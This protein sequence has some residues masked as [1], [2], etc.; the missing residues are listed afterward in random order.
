MC[1]KLKRWPKPT[2][3]DSPFLAFFPNPPVCR[4]S[5][6][7][8]KKFPTHCAVAKS[9]QPMVFLLQPTA[10]AD[11]CTRCVARKFMLISQ[12]HGGRE[13]SLPVGDA[14]LICQSYGSSI[15]LNGHYRS[16]DHSQPS[17]SG[18]NRISVVLSY[19]QNG[20]IHW[21][22][23]VLSQRI[24]PQSLRVTPHPLVHSKSGRTGGAPQ[25]TS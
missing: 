25:N 17:T 15:H 12:C 24:T 16:A 21:T 11:R 8:L 18:L 19:C 1:L 23:V 6:P 7:L 20:W 9:H 5:R 10:R 13:C 4:T 14:L 2:F 22:G 3:S